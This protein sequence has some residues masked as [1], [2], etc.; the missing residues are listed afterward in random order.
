MY[1]DTDN[2]LGDI[3]RYLNE[4]QIKNLRGANWNTARISEMLRNPVYVEANIDVYQF[5]KVKAQTSIIRQVISR[6]TMPAISTKVLF[7]LQESKVTCPTKRLCLRR[8]RVLSPL[9]HG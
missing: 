3:V 6:V 2:S 1:A 4:H 5:S 8:I 7:P 9:R